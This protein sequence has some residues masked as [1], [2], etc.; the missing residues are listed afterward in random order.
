[1]RVLFL[2]SFSEVAVGD[3]A[4]SLSLAMAGIHQSACQYASVLLGVQA[5][6]TQTFVEFITRFDCLY[7][8]L[9]KQWKS[10]NNR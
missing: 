5:F 2:F 4:E 1:M 10:K 7:N 9:L 3:S 6:S 8:K